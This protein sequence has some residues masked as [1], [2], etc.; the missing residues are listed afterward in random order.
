MIRYLKSVGSE[1]DNLTFGAEGLPITEEQERE[2]LSKTN[3]NAF[4]VIAVDDDGRIVGDASLERGPR[5]MS[6]AAELGISTLKSYWGQGIG[7]RLMQEMI[8]HAKEVG[9]TKINLRV[10][11]DNERAKALYRKFGFEKEG[12][13]RRMMMIDGEYFDGEHWGLVL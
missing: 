11:A 5:R 6:H 7:S 12:D 13:D 9:I 3:P 8:S 4:I 2:F 10:R 1:S